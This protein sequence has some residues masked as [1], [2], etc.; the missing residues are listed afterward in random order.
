MAALRETVALGVVTNLSWLGRL[1]ESDPVV[2]GETHT[3]LLE[4]LLLPAPPP[5]ADEVFAAAASVLSGASCVARTSTEST[6][7][8]PFDTPFRMGGA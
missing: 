7:S 6:W 3:G 8:G 1:L 4:T 2:R 5:P